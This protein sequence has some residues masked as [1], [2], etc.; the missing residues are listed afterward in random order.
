MS[1]LIDGKVRTQKE[2]GVF[3]NVS[4]ERIR[5]IESAALSQ[6]RSLIV[7]QKIDFYN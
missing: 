5:Q 3:L 7:S 2:V 6:L 1:G 4:A